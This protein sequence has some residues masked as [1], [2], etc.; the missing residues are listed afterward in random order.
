MQQRK[1]AR[2]DLGTRS[3]REMRPQVGRKTHGTIFFPSFSLTNIEQ[4]TT[5]KCDDIGLEKY[6]AELKGYSTALL[7]F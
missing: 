1:E 7:V 5:I 6:V 2:G 3:L 4:A